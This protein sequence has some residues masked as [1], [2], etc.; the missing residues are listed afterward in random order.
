MS[1]D[2]T[3]EDNYSDPGSMKGDEGSFTAEFAEW[4]LERITQHLGDVPSEDLVETLSHE[5]LKEFAIRLGHKGK[6]K[7]HQ[8]VMYCAHKPA[9][10]K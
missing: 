5:L 7:D 3:T 8:Q 2:G 6:T 9:A 1:L 10:Y 4:L